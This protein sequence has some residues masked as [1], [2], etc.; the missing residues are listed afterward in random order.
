MQELA[1]VVITYNRHECLSRLLA[2]LSAAQFPAGNIPLV[3]SIDP[4]QNARIVEIAR[5]FSWI[6]GAK[7]VI[8]H[9]EHLGLRNHVL[10]CGDLTKRYGSVILLEDDLFVS[11]V[12]YS[13]SLECIQ[14]YAEDAK[15]AGISLYNQRVNK[16]CFRPFE[17][18]H[19]GSDMYFLQVASSWGQVWTAEQ[20]HRFRAWYNATPRSV[21][22]EDYLPS[23]VISWPETSWLKYFIKYMVE[24]DLYFV[25]PRK[26]FTTNCGEPGTH[27]QESLHSWF[28]VPIQL[29]RPVEGWRFASF[30]ESMSIYDVF[31]ELLPACIARVVPSMA[32]TDF[33]VDL[34]GT[35]PLTKIR[36]SH[37]LTCRPCGTSVSSFGCSLK[38][39]DA[40]VLLG[41]SGDQFRLAQTRT[42]MEMPSRPKWETEYDLNL[43]PGRALYGYLIRN[44]IGRIERRLFR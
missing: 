29:R 18:I 1:I 20:W 14:H 36:T 16:N 28:Q 23:E 31:F 44:M 9:Q 42:V 8:V 6:H 17:A 40:N 21:T 30:D 32:G 33:T 37:L 35:K 41:S 11:P 4:S 10:T 38:P 5:S 22:S 15:V 25:Y 12:F 39:R 7:E 3:I 19:D 43:R 26:S 27:I 2:S 24:K 34:Y 13:Y